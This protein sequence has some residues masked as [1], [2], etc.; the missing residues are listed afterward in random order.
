MKNL[1]RLIAAFRDVAPAGQPAAF[2]VSGDGTVTDAAGLGELTTTLM[3]AV[4]DFVESA[5][6][7]VEPKE[8][9]GLLSAVSS[10]ISQAVYADELTASL[11]P[12][13]FA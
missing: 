8:V 7:I 6:A 11:S 13:A 1:D 5:S 4:A 3:H 9:A 10:S 12:E 2:I